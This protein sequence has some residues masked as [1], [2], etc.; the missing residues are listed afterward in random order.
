MYL[1]QLS[2]SYYYQIIKTIQI[3]I[4][5]TEEKKTIQAKDCLD[6]YCLK[7]LFLRCSYC[8]DLKKEKNEMLRIQGF[9]KF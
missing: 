6:L 3:D 2:L 5:N 7:Q 8:E 4:I 9:K 1:D